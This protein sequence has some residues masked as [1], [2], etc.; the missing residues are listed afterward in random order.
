M[1]IKLEHAARVMR[2]SLTGR[3]E[4]VATGV[5][6]NS[7]E[8]SPGD[9]FF[10]LKGRV[11]DGHDYVEAALAGGAA[12]VVTGREMLEIDDPA[13]SVIVTPSP[14]HALVALG[15][16]VRDTE[17][18]LV[19][20]ITGSTGKTSVKDLLGAVA[21]SCMPTIASKKSFNND[22]GVPLTLCSIKPETEVVVCE[23]G[24]RGPGHIARLCEY[25]RPHIG[26]V[27]NI[28]LTHFEQFGGQS[29]IADAKGELIS[30]LPEGGA[31]ILNSDDPLV[32]PMAN[33]S[34]A[35]VM[36][37]GLNPQADVRAEDIRFNDLG[38]PTFRIAYRGDAVTVA[39]RVA[40]LHQ[41][42]NS[43]AAAAGAICLGL[44]LGDCLRG[45]ENASVS[46]W[47]M[48]VA[49]HQGVRFV[50]DAYNASPSSV[51]SAIRTC[52]V[53]AGGSGRLIVVL[54]HMAELGSIS[55][56]EHRRVGELAATLA[57]RL[58]VVGS[59]TIPAAEAAIGAGM[60]EVEVAAD[61]D[62][63][64]QAVG[65]LGPGDVVLVKASRVAGLEAVTQ[66]AAMALNTP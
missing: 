66:M 36:T 29:Q 40:G 31:A 42:S 14:E 44:S 15:A 60:R 9:L 58:V 49:V 28:G 61:P 56:N 30:S 35:N 8:V 65:P 41:V 25:A 3:P 18:P 39:L 63:A 55:E 51:E 2:G 48:E 62:S 26:I 10:A 13:A 12:A 4:A 47:R 57:S 33:L 20:G 7:G 23:M 16:W 38:Q 43:L 24:S 37:F 53:M 34:D 1:K 32:M 19:V 27:T 54:G 5:S 59:Q 11:Q 64:A 21:G 46:Q 52:A 22:L 45:L 50:N 6:I 17:D